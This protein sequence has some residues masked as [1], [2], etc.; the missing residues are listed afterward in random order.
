MLNSIPVNISVFP[1]FGPL[2]YG[3]T[4]FQFSQ[5]TMTLQNRMNVELLSYV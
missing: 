5:I 1:A 3:T 2:Q 4:G